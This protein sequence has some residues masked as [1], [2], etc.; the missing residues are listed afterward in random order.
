MIG[1]FLLILLFNKNT[2]LKFM[3]NGD[4]MS[5]IN[6]ISRLSGVSKS[7][8]SRYL[9][10]GSVSKKTGMKIQKVIDKLN[11]IPNAF[12]QSL[13]S[14]KTNTIGAI[15]PNFI[16]FSKNISLTAIDKYLREHSYKL[17]ISNSNDD[18]KEEI[19]LIYSLASQRV[20]GIILF[21]SSITSEHH[22]VINNITIP[23]VIIGQEVDGVHCVVHND[24]KAGEILG[25]YIL[26]TNHKKIAYF[27][28]GDYDLNVKKR[29]EGMM[30]V[31]SKNNDIIVNYYLV[32]F[33]SQKAYRKTK[34]VYEVDDATYYVGATDNIA[35]GII[36]GLRELGVDI[37][38]KISVSGFG[39]YEMSELMYPMLTTIKYSYYDI[40]QVATKIILELIKD[41]EVEKKVILGCELKVRNSTAII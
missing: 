20:D 31:L 18:M 13:K 21:A 4:K 8:V 37:P 26:S 36:K 41:K 14:N 7:T 17:L 11:Y 27:G 29:Y 19:K 28:V 33:D 1:F 25:E 10:D 39:D 23:I 3:V 32:G 35:F 22:E 9:N 30:S 34:E 6:D 16:G 24:Y 2:F 12:A 15:I 40:G 5:N 38:K